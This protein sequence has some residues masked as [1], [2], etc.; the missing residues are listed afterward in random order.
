MLKVKLGI[1]YEHLHS[2]CYLKD[3]DLSQKVQHDVKPIKYEILTNGVCQTWIP[4]LPDLLVLVL[5]YLWKALFV[6]IS[7]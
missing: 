6:T 3:L 5:F 7:T 2:L 4:D 1:N